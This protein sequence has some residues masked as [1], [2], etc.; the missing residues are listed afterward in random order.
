MGGFECKRANPDGEQ[1]GHPHGGEAGS[2]GAENE[3]LHLQGGAFA[4][5][6]RPSGNSPLTTPS[7]SHRP[8]QAAT[9]VRTP[10]R[11]STRSC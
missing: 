7:Y 2:N 4:A 6:G 5:G 8:G 11:G 10:Y 1:A 3:K 9:G